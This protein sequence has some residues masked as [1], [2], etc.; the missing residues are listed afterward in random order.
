MLLVVVLSKP[1]NWGAYVPSPEHMLG[2]FNVFS[3]GTSSTSETVFIVSM[4][5]DLMPQLFRHN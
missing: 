5:L 3:L 1:E 4:D 2:R